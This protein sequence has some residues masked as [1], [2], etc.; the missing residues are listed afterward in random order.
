MLDIMYQNLHFDI[1]ILFLIVYHRL[2]DIKKG[3]LI[4]L[5]NT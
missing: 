2:K 1:V 3:K 5:E 4:I